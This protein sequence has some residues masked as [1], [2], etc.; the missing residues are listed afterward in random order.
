MKAGG[1]LDRSGKGLPGSIWHK[2]VFADSV[3]II[4]P[5]CFLPNYNNELTSTEIYEKADPGSKHLAKFREPVEE[6]V[7]VQTVP[8]GEEAGF[9]ESVAFNNLLTR[10]RAWPP[11]NATR[12]AIK[13]AQQDARDW[14]VP[15]NAIRAMIHITIRR[16]SWTDLAE[17]LAYTIPDVIGRWIGPVVK[18]LQQVP[19][20]EQW[21]FNEYGGFI[22]RN[23]RK[24][25]FF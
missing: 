9:G 22:D 15:D 8:D 1:L 18:C 13:R 17:H 25:F 6:S 24:W 5:F 14:G 10:H 7:F 4:Y 23:D 19:F 20:V 16:K 12:E 11:A 2:D 21:W 3:A